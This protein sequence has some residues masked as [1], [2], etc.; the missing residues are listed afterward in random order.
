MTRHNIPGRNQAAIQGA[1]GKMA[2]S[3]SLGG[4]SQ[5]S[6]PVT[7][8]APRDRDARDAALV[9]AE[10]TETQKR[11]RG[12]RFY[13]TKAQMKHLPL[14]DEVGDLDSAPIRVHYFGGSYDA[15]VAGVDADGYALA[16]VR[17]AHMPE[18]A[19]WGTIDLAELERTNVYGTVIERD[20][21]WEPVPA[22]EIPDYRALTPSSDSSG[23]EFGSDAWYEQRVQ[24]LEDAGLCT[25]DAQATAEG[26][27]LLERQNGR[28]D[29][30]RDEWVCQCGNTAD[31]SGFFPFHGSGMEVEPTE[32]L[33]DG[34]S[35][36][37]AGCN[38]VFNQESGV[39]LM[40]PANI[41]TLEG[42][43]LTV[44]D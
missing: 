14:I 31:S 38:R 3:I 32:D 15:W 37:C 25:S 24:Q 34:I 35:M 11:R 23:Y 43:V 41:R 1:G 28:I 40:R 20:M 4:A 27:I 36:F 30:S 17:F 21:Y 19:E 2:G 8:T 42:V 26:E 16:Y 9:L 33:W 6:T 39:V 10:K 44:E 22:R 5:P 7:V 18:C 13:P 29:T 12:H